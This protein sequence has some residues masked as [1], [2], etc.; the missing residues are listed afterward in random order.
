MYYWEEIRKRIGEYGTIQMEDV[1][2]LLNDLDK[3]KQ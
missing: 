2:E 3:C 1:Q